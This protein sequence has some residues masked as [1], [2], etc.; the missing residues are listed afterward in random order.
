VAVNGAAGVVKIRYVGSPR[1]NDGI[2]TE[3]G[4]FTFHEFTTSTTFIVR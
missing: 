1:F 2:V 3:S 4:G